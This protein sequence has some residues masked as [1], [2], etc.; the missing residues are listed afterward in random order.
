MGMTENLE[1]RLQKGRFLLTRLLL[2]IAGKHRRWNESISHHFKSKN[3][4]H[5]R[6]TRQPLHSLQIPPVV[7]HLEAPPHFLHPLS[8]L[9]STAQSLFTQ[10]SSWF[11]LCAITLLIYKVKYLQS[12]YYRWALCQA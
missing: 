5:K 6:Y 7:H 9:H 11:S 4:T 3:K 2:R 12:A 1:P 10:I 8:V